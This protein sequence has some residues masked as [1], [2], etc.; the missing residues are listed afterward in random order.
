VIERLLDGAAVDVTAGEQVRDYCH[1]D[2]HVRAFLRAGVAP[3]AAPVRVFNVGRGEPLRIRDLL[4]LLAQAVGGDA[5][6]RLRFGALPC[7][8][9][10]TPEMWCSTEAARAELG[11]RVQVALDDG[12]RRTVAWHRERREVG[13]D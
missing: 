12:L 11:F 7:R 6:A 5:A 9:D 3:L 1:V 10:E 13:S 8:P 4:L 2:D